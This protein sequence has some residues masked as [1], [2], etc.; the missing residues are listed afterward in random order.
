[1]GVVGRIAHIV[2]GFI[3]VLSA[4]LSPGL[5]IVFFLTFL[6]YQSFEYHAEKDI[7]TDEL[8]EYAAGLVLGLITFFT[9]IVIS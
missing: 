4:Y 1:M 5:P 7:P 9:Y 8:V 3:T 2:F 6:A